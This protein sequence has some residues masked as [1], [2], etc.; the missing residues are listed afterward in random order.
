MNKATNPTDFKDLDCQLYD[1]S[2]RFI[3]TVTKKL[4]V[5]MQL[6]ADEQALEG[7]IFLFNHFSR[8]ETF[9]PQF[10]IHEKTG[11]YCC[12]IAS[13]EFFENNALF[14]AYLNNV[15]VI[16][17]DHPRLFANLARQVFLGRKIIIFPEGGMVKDH[18][19]LDAQGNYSIYSRIT[20]KRR[21]Q[22]TGAA[23]LAQGIEVLK[24]II[25]QAYSE[26]DN[27]QLLHWQ[28]E[29]GLNSVAQ[30]LTA[31][32]K[33]T[34]I[35]PANITFYPIRTAENLLLKGVE[36]FTDGLSV[37][38]TEELLIEGN[39]LL[40]ATDM[41][42]RLGQPIDLHTI[43]C[44]S[45]R[46]LL[47]KATTQMR[48]L[49]AIFSL[50]AQPK[51]IKHKLLG[52][53]F[54][55]N[56][57]IT[58]NHYMQ[59]MYTY[60][61]VNL[62]HL[63]SALI[64]SC[65]KQ[66]Q[67]QIN[68]QQFYTLLYAAIKVLQKQR[69]IHLHRSLLTV[70][71]YGGLVDGHCQRLEQFMQLSESSG[72]IAYADGEYRFLAKLCKDFDFDAIRM[73]NLIVVY[74][75]EVAPIK[76]VEAALVY[77]LEHCAQASL[78][79]LAQWRF[80]DEIRALSWD[81]QQY[82]K[83]PYEELNRQQTITA[84]PAPFLLQPAQGNGVGM[85]LIHGLLASPA[86]LKAYAEY[87]CKQG[88]T[89]L[90]VRLKGHGTSP[91]DLRKQT[92][93]AWYS[94]VQRGLSI[95]TAYCDAVVAVGFSTGAA[96]ALKLAAENSDRISA[97]VAVSVPVKFVDKSFLFI[98]LLH[99]TNRL[100]EWVASIEG[101]KPFI[102]NS[103]EHPTINYRHVP[104]RSLYELTCLIDNVISELEQVVAPTL[105]INADGDPVVHLDSA[106]T[107]LH[108]LGSTRKEYVC[109]HADRHGILME[110]SGGIWELIEN[111]L[112]K[113][114][115]LNDT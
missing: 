19:V 9:I 55:K 77:A 30:L 80:D 60:V 49:A 4:K 56:A 50:D 103:P 112:Q 18:R 2:V 62:S 107:I 86:E 33:P 45:N 81:Q 51:N 37:R 61:T 97:V 48:S 43:G 8:F 13:S 114:V 34:L 94:S 65:L 1:W 98:P 71:E 87:L 84:E 40:K 111:F 20:G 96:L 42:L 79:Q 17:H 22:H 83:A 38:Q 57:A 41:D 70:E 26:Q 21:K 29:L 52:Y 11:N 95:I 5:N 15:G 93:Q 78:Q 113:N 10:L 104:V 74:S 35:V 31:A 82:A 6:H 69:D 89:V 115:L 58:R 44:W 23:V 3:R 63:A 92:F 68:K 7:D 59:E 75:N 16:A 47:S 110:N 76:A 101:V 105:I 109:I 54:R 53:Y 90:A 106:Q 102:E 91:H 66:G 88:Y 24:A 27:A 14:A 67:Q 39:I 36:L 73:E 64:M 28:A 100:V 46:Y 85:L 99:G 12:S 72:L 25:R 108:G 32:L